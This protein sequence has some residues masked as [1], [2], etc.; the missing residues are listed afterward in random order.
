M[1]EAGFPLRRETFYYAHRRG[2][3]QLVPLDIEAWVVENL[4]VPD[5]ADWA[6]LDRHGYFQG[7][8]FRA[9]VAQRDRVVVRALPKGSWFGEREP[10]FSVTGPSALVSFLE[11]LALQLHWRIQ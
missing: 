2:G 8:A 9:A 1:A 10:V 4:P 7:G 11:P 6:F 3:W 5:A